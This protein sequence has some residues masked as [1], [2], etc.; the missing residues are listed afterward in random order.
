MHQRRTFIYLF[1]F[2][3]ILLCVYAGPDA[4]PAAGGA[5]DV[6]YM[7]L[8]NSLATSQGTQALCRLTFFAPYWVDNRTGLDLVFHDHQ[9]APKSALLFGARVPFDTTS[10]RVNGAGKPLHPWPWLGGCAPC[11]PCKHG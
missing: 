2:G 10:V 11:K 1:I 9:S 5:P 3:V 8:D 7:G 4:P 6:L